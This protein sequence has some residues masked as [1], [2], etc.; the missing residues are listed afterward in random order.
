MILRR[1]LIWS[2]F[3]NR[4]GDEKAADQHRSGMWN[5]VN[6]NDQKEHKGLICPE[7]LTGV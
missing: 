5:G 6:S 2:V 1:R 4:R 3:F 7:I